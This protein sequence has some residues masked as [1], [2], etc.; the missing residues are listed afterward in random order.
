MRNLIEAVWPTDGSIK[1]ILDLGCGDLWFT[2]NLPGVE[3]HVGID[4]HQPSLDKA[5]Q[6]NPIGFKPLCMDAQEYCRLL[7][8]GAF[9][10]VLAIDFVEHLDEDRFRW[11]LGEIERVA[12]QLAI[13]WTTMGYIEQ[14]PFSNDGEPNKYQRHLYGPTVEDFEG[15]KVDTY[16]E[17]H[18]ARGGAIFAVK[19]IKPQKNDIPGYLMPGVE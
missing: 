18:G 15:W 5:W 8:D 7:P 1:R 4:L 12:S 2:Y 9:D 17:W 13:I 10:A 14:G 6:K 11:M 3:E 16:P 19:H